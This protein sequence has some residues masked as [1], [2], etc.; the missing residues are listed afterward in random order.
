M[1]TQNL[2]MVPMETHVATMQG[3]Q[4]ITLNMMMMVKQLWGEVGG[5]LSDN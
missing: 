3:G 4:K 1:G 2:K 5:S